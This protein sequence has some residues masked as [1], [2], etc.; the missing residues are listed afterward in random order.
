MT[1]HMQS[2]QRDRSAHTAGCQI[3]TL[4]RRLNF[5]GCAAHVAAEL[6]ELAAPVGK[7]AVSAAAPEAAAQQ[8][9]RRP[10]SGL[11][12]DNLTNVEL[13]ILGELGDILVID[14]AI[15][16][17]IRLV[18]DVVGQI[19]GLEVTGN[20]TG[21]LTAAGVQID[22]QFTSTLAITS[23]GPGKCEVVTLDLGGLNIDAL[24]LVT[25]DVPELNV[26]AQGSG[27]VGVLLCTLGSVLRGLTGS[28]GAAG[29]LTNAVNDQI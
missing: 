28:G 11:V 4:E 13:P 19:V 8:G 6:A 5:C 1:S 7:N 24:G 12:V 18:E 26:N 9:P 25:A 20:V 27:A 16:T 29:G 17:D 2:R 21:L 22:E 14:Q 23:S 15:I 10:G 3:D